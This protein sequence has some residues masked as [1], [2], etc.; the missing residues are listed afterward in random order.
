MATCKIVGILI[1]GEGV[2]AQGTYIYASCS[3]SPAIIQGTSTGIVP[4]SLFKLTTSTG[5]F[6]MD[7]VR[8]VNFTIHIPEMGFKKTIRVPNE[9]GPINLWSLSDVYVTGD[10]TPEDAGDD[11]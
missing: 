5:T 7:L 3:D 10:P 6:E 2:G 9:A 1:T 11:W 8:N 4:E